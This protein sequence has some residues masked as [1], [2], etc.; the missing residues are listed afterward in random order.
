VSGP[1]DRAPKEYVQVEPTQC[2][3]AEGQGG[4]PTNVD[5]DHP[6]TSRSESSAR[7]H[8]TPA[9]EPGDL[10]EASSPRVGGK[11]LQEGLRPQSARQ[12]SEKSD[13]DVVPK[14]LTKT[15]VTPVESMEGRS[16]A[17]GNAVHLRPSRRISREARVHNLKIEFEFE[18]DFRVSTPAA[19]NVSLVLSSDKKS[20]PAFPKRWRGIGFLPPRRCAS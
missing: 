11:Q 15:W 5:L 8:T 1:G 4:G 6:L 3:H 16:A 20:A 2:S 10:G 9:R 19:P 14:K 7:S 13:A 12:R 17:K 18:L